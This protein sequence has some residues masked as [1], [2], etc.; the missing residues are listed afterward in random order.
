MMTTTL[1][2]LLFIVLSDLVRLAQHKTPDPFPLTSD[3]TLNN[4]YTGKR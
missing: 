3:I 2:S 4:D 1:H